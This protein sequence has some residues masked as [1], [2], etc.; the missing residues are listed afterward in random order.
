MVFQNLLLI[1]HIFFPAATQD[2]GLLQTKRSS[3]LSLYVV[4][5]SEQSL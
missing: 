4:L 3:P 5:R 1:Y 2:K